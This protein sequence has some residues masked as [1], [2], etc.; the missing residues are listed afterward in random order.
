MTEAIPTTTAWGNL[1]TTVTN[2]TPEEIDGFDR[3]SRLA[4]QYGT[5]KW[6]LHSYTP[7]YHELF[8]ADRHL[9]LKLLEIGVGGYGDPKAGG[10]SLAMWR[11]YFPNATLIGIDVLPKEIDLGERVT[12][13][14]GSQS[15]PAFML[16]IAR[17]FGPFD[18]V[19]DDGSHV[20]TDV[21]NSF[22]ILWPWMA[23]YGVYVI[24]DVQTAF[25]PG[26]GGE[27]QTGGVTGKLLGRLW[28]E[29]HHNEIRIETP[30]VELM[31][32][33]PRLDSIQ[34]FHNMLVIQF[35]ENIEPSCRGFIP[36]GRHELARVAQ[37][38]SILEQHPTAAGWAGVARMY[39]HMHDKDYCLAAVERALG[40]SETDPNV[41]AVVREIFKENTSA[42]LAARKTVV[43]QEVA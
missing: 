36:T 11:D 21:G 14:Q 6:G 34:A 22:N 31:A 28:R 41:L 35:G 4:I 32:V 8:E 1:S 5:D 25:W 15:D 33:G 3:L 2:V 13:R 7:I 16:S 37:M 19:I 39:Y 38:E 17:E 10:A 20:P 42:Y 9:P 23:P 29:L 43:K 30:N 18:I 12:I 26:H 24:E 40:I 27:M